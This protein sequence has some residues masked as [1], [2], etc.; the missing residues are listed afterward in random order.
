MIDGEHLREWEGIGVY[1][2]GFVEVDGQK[3]A[4]GAGR[5][6]YENGDLY[7]G[8]WHA[9]CKQ[10]AGPSYLMAFLPHVCP[11]A[12]DQVA[13]R[14]SLR[15]WSSCATDFVLRIAVRRTFLLFLDG[16]CFSCFLRALTLHT[17]TCIIQADGTKY[18][19]AWVYDQMQGTG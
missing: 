13:A 7:E 3:V 6:E 14:V 2:G 19:G 9:G 1:K 5:F 11:C 15:T 8:E 10:G 17:G 16:V 12:P 18:T 4:Q